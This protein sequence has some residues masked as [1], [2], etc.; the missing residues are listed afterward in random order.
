NNLAV[1]QTGLSHFDVLFLRSG[2]LLALRLEN[3]SLAMYFRT[4]AGDNSVPSLL[5]TMSV[6]SPRG[7]RRAANTTLFTTR[8]SRAFRLSGLPGRFF[9]CA[10]PVLLYR[11][12]VS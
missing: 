9:G 8:W 5:L 4:V 10:E 12:M 2:F 7:W 3:P 11:A 6:I 1:Y